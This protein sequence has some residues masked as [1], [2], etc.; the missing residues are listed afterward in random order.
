MDPQQE[1]VEIERAVVRDHDLAVEDTSLRESRPER[2]GQLREV[3]IERLQVARLRVDVVA[4]AEDE[5]P[6]AVPLGLEQPA[7]VARQ[8]VGRL[9]QHRL[10]RGLEGECHGT[11]IPS[12]ERRDGGSRLFA[13][14]VP[15]GWRR[16]RGIRRQLGAAGVEE[17]QDLVLLHDGEPG[18]RRD[19]DR[20]RIVGED[21]QV[22]GIEPGVAI[23][24]DER[25]VDDPLHVPL[26][27]ECSGCDG[28]EP[29]QRDDADDDEPVPDPADP[30]D[31]DEDRHDR[32]RR[33]QA[34][35][36]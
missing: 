23:G 7:V 21:A 29:H 22:V 3:A 20:D 31:G 8:R 19:E 17:E 34:Q 18:E 27:D 11:T 28:T 35:R 13:S 36:S 15:G 4:V 33:R 30:L 5:R 6:E 9:R 12:R 25:R 1:G 10:D 16:E 26:G 32:Q 24:R 2:V 14:Q